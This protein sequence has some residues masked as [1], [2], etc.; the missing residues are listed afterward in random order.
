MKELPAP[1]LSHRT[2]DSKMNVRFEV[3]T[4][5]KMEA[6]RP[7]ETL[8]SYFITARCHDPAT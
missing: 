4:E 2:E 7:S 1:L 8:V 6:V 5:V 3:F